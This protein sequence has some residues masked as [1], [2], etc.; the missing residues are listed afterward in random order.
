MTCQD[1]TLDRGFSARPLTRAPVSPLL[2]GP[3][4]VPP[5]R[6]GQSVTVADALIAGML[7]IYPAIATVV[8]VV[9]GLVLSG[10]GAGV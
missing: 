7:V 3:F 10:P 9:V 2:A 1:D 4:D 5:E 6:E 8:A